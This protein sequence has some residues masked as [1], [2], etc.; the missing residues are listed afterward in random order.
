L[1]GFGRDIPALLRKLLYDYYRFFSHG[2][3][4]SDG[5]RI[6]EELARML[7]YEHPEYKGLIRRIRRNP[8]IESMRKLSDIILG[9][10]VYDEIMDIVINGPYTYKVHMKK[11]SGASH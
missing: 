1:E 2:V 9:E 5:R 8:T 7:I 10:K 4:N 6:F 11:Y 3:L